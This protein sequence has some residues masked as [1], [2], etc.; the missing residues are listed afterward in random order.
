MC[1]CIVASKWDYHRMSDLKRQDKDFMRLNKTALGHKATTA[2]VRKS[3]L[4]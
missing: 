3:K 2:H 1:L 4:V